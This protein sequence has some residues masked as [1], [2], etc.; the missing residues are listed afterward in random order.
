MTGYNKTVEINAPVDKVF[1]A[2]T[3]GLAYWWTTG[4]G[5]ATRLGAVFTTRFGKTYNHI[6]VTRLVPDREVD[7]QVVEQYHAS[8][9][10]NHHDE[11]TGTKIIWR[12]TPVEAA[13]TRL[14]FTHE[15][16][17]QSME[18]WSICEAGWNFFLLQSLRTYLETG[19]GQPFQHG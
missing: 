10:L 1:E 8:E 12:L 17:V 16:L 2:I 11:W 14:D 3:E 4:V 6:K 7:W 19:Q 15:G 5:E 9:D 13:K 18:C